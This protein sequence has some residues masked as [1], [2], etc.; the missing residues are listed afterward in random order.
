[1]YVWFRIRA[2]AET[3]QRATHAFAAPVEDMG[4][5]HFV[6]S[7]SI[8]IGVKALVN[9]SISYFVKHQLRPAKQ[10]FFK[11]NPQMCITP[12]GTENYK[13]QVIRQ[14]EKVK[15]AKEIS[16]IEQGMANIEGKP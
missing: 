4:I 6:I 12:L 16:N 8:P 14:K 15:K 10:A 2:A 7:D 13:E 9:N 11:L 3:F 1:M 5:D